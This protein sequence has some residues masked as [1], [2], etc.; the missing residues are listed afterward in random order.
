VVHG[1]DG[2]D[3]MIWPV[4]AAPAVQVTVGAGKVLERGDRVKIMQR[5]PHMNKLAVVKGKDLTTG[6]L[7]YSVYSDDPEDA[8]SALISLVLSS[9]RENRDD[10]QVPRHD[11]LTFP[12]QPLHTIGHSSSMPCC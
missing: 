3:A 4:D 10:L 2:A 7:R 1:E 5:G 11:R 9:S 6:K 8:R 12:R